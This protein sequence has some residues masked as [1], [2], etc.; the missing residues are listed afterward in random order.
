MLK[1]PVVY[2]K[3]KGLRTTRHDTTAACRQGMVEQVFDSFIKRICHGRDHMVVG[4]IT[5]Y[6]ISQHSA[7]H[8]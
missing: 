1:L 2:D 3:N 4:F 5:T 8:Q 7:Y 6:A